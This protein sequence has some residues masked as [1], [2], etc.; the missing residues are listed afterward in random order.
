MDVAILSLPGETFHNGEI[1]GPHVSQL[2]NRFSSQRRHFEHEYLK[3]RQVN[4]NAVSFRKFKLGIAR[5]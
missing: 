5:Q 2:R 3:F 1:G 4:L